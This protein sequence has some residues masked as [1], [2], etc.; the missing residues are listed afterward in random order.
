MASLTPSSRIA[1]LAA[2]K[3]TRMRS[4]IPKIF[5]TLQG[6][7]LVRYVVDAART[8]NGDRPILVLSPEHR[9]AVERIFGGEVAYVVQTEQRGTGHAVMSIPS[10]LLAGSQHL[11]VLY[12]D[13]PLLTSP[14]IRRLIEAHAAAHCPLTM[15]TTTVPSF[16]GQYEEFKTFG[17]VL[18]QAD[19]TLDRIVEY[20]DAS[21][22]V[23]AV[24]EVNPGYYCFNI[25]WLYAHL[26]RLKD[27]NA[28][29]EYYLTDLVGMARREGTTV[30]VVPIDEPWEGFGVN[31]P[32]ALVLAEQ[33]LQKRMK[34]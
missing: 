34:T 23:K 29:K 11:V 18:R 30:A 15:M 9:A 13:Q 4:P 8:A 22:G 2:G 12:G 21:D 3:S 17:R 28:Q 19:G 6:Q 31:T 26:P 33:L 25:T 10:E 5:H 20:K 16:E 32:E 7:P 14:T 24:R 27:E 1:I